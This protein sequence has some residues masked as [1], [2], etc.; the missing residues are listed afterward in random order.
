[1]YASFAVLDYFCDAN[2]RPANYSEAIDCNVCASF[3]FIGKR[4]AIDL[5]IEEIQVNIGNHQIIKTLP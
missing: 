3:T 4:D 2:Q 1:M 5:T